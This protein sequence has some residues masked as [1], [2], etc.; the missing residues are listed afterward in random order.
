MTAAQGPSG[1]VVPDVAQPRVLAVAER[2]LVRSDAAGVLPTPLD[3]VASCAGIEEVLDVSQLPPPLAARKPSFLR[4][5]VGAL[6]Y[7]E[8]VAFIDYSQ[9][10][11][12][13]RFIEAHEI[14]HRALPWHRASHELF[15]DDEGTLH[16]DTEL[17]LE[18]EA[19]LL[20]AHLLFQGHRFHQ[21]ALD[22]QL[23]LATPTLLAPQFGASL[24][25]T[26]RFYVEHHPEPVALAIT[27]QY[28]GSDGTVPVWTAL[29]SPTFAAHHGPF[30]AWFPTHRLQ[31]ADRD[32]VRP[33]GQLAVRA[34]AGERQPDLVLRRRHPD[35]GTRHYRAEAF[36]NQRCLFLMVTPQRRLKLGRRVRLAS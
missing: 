30:Q 26:I 28:R 36:Y 25:A 5:V 22:Y 3:A 16:P 14:G 9:P 7:R 13:A 10:D 19:N 23:T 29:S 8:S 15:Q 4:R 17:E 6:W 11:A 27:G 34:L 35:G 20:A 12:R 33:L 31:V 24:T 32:G 2:L 21:Q 18:A 1:L